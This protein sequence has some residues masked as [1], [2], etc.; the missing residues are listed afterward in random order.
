MKQSLKKKI[1]LITF[2]RS[3][4]GQLRDLIFL[5]KKEKK[6]NFQFI[7]SGSHFYKKKGLTIKEIIKDKIHINYKIKIRINKFNSN[8][9]SNHI[10]NYIK[11][12]S[13]IFIKIKPDIILILGDRYETFSAA[14]SALAN[15]IPIGHF[16]G[17]EVTRGVIDDS[18]R[19][20]ITKMSNMHFV[21]NKLFKKRVMQL[22]ENPKYI[23]NVGSLT[24]ERAKNFKAKA[25][26]Y[27]EKKFSFK[28][29]AKNLLI[30]IHPLKNLSET[31]LMI[32]NLKISL[33]KLKKDNLLIFTSPNFDKDA[34]IIFNFIKNFK[35][36]NIV[37]INN[38]GYE[39]YLS[40]MKYCDL[41]I[42]NSS[43]IFTEAPILN[44]LSINI[45]SRQA[46]RPLTKTIFQ[47]DYKH[48]NITKKINYLLN[49]KSKK[50]IRMNKYHYYKKRTKF[51]IIKKIKKINFQ[52]I[53]Q[54]NF[55]DLK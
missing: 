43:S 42:G 48:S 13:K 4:Y 9:I 53:I 45:G 27:L 46:G 35:K 31:K 47:T 19:H 14:I 30:T 23:Y 18:F 41:V 24:A 5:L 55:F 26:S 32:K 40:C 22:G 8:D 7:V 21:A 17:G 16:H 51:E 3:D 20:S 12:F 50:S 28:F 44:K 10:A 54:K 52:E 29:L 15:N 2:D 34:N 25:K 36:K 6:I 33:Q 1:C 38:F 11:E 39:N 49:F 37:Y